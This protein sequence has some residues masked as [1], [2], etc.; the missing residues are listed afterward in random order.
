MVHKQI[1]RVRYPLLLSSVFVYQPSE[2]PFDDLSSWPLSNDM[3]KKIR[4]KTIDEYS[5]CIHWNSELDIISLKFK[6]CSDVYYACYQCH[7]ELT[8]HP[9]KRFDLN[10]NPDVKV[11][12]CGNCCKEMTFEE[13]VESKN[14]YDRLCCFNC[15][16]LFNPGCKLHYDLYFELDSDKYGR[17]HD[18]VDCKI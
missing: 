4:G 17:D 12:I 10:A 14:E 6:C 18:I 11:I 16:S 9:V 15:Q 13:Y 8:T 2:A 5:R 3:S 7:E 1:T